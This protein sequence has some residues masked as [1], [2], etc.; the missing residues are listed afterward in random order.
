VPHEIIPIGEDDLASLH[1]VVE[2]AFGHVSD[3]ARVDEERLIIEY[4]R[5]FGVREGGE[6]VAGG[7]AFSFD[8]TLPGLATLPV[9]GVTWIGVLPSHRRRGI[10][11]KMM[12]FQLDDI[13]A[14]GES[15]AVL[16]ASEAVIYGRFGYGV[17]TQVVQ[18]EIA[19]PRGT[20]HR[21]P[22]ISARFRMVW[23]DDAREPMASV[24]D[25][26]RRQR[27]GAISRNAGVWQMYV[28]DREW[29]RDGGSPMFVVLHEDSSGQP[30]GYARYRT[31]DT[32]D[33]ESKQL[34]VLEVIAVDPE[35]EAALWRFVLDVDLIGT[36]VGRLQPVDD[37]L[38]WRL[39]D[40][41]A[42]GV[43]WLDDFMWAR[44]LD[45]PAALAARTYAT[46]SS[47]VFEVADAFRPSG[48]A[49][50]RFQLDGGPDG[51][52]C[53]PTDASPDIALPVE[54]LGAI[55]LGAVPLSTYVAAGRASGAPDAVARADAM[56]RS[57][58]LPF[59]NTGF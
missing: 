40:S 14:R 4:D 41:R 44:L 55:W 21:I 37:P 50:G 54:V 11:T 52:S 3:P 38:Q 34:I 58:P 22:D 32:G 49:A 1:R 35:V 10:L 56:F 24:Y 39:R 29:N 6:L 36:V 20:F 8:V 23:G 33:F 47:L 51:A 31:K 13:A 9:A 53:K 15:V 42:Y 46:E 43:K 28:N 7:G 12:E 30:D 25:E 45:V 57:T 18:V 19:K 48:A 2:T 27:P 5:M 16:T 26:W 59:C 17:T